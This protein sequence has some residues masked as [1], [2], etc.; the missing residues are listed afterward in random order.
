MPSTLIIC[1][2]RCFAALILTA[3]LGAS[4]SRAAEPEELPIVIGIQS[5][6]N[7]LIMAA[8]TQ[9]LFEKAGLKPSFIKFTAGAPMMAAA[10]SQSIDVACVGL[11]PF[12]AGIGQGIPWVTIGIPLV[13]PNAEGIVVR[14]D[15][16]KWEE[17]RTT[18][19][20]LVREAKFATDCLLEGDG[21]EP[22]V[23]HTKRPFRL[24]R[25]V[26]QFAFRDKN[27]LFRARD[28]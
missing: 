15:S 27:R 26:P 3:A 4:A 2:V 8:R 18:R 12:M 11:V 7:W 6:A 10:Q 1:A 23:P 20:S 25:S 5:D 28:R 19:A 22:S 14:K 24:P 16:G 9:H 17:L 13:D 21:F